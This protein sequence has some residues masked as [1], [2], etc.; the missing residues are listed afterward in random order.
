MTYES[1]RSAN[2]WRALDVID[3]A[4]SMAEGERHAG[5]DVLRS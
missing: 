4:T 5:G 2:T 1:H 3:I